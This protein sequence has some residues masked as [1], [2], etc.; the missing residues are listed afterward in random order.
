MPEQAVQS[1]VYW[2]VCKDRNGA[3]TYQQQP[4]KEPE[5]GETEVGREHCLHALLARNAHS[6]V[7][8]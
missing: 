2:H 4:L 6:D 5:L 8:F 3:K 1:N 7:R